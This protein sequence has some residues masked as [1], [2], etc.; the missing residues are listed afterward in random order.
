MMRGTQRIALAGK[1]TKGPASR[2]TTGWYVGMRGHT[3]GAAQLERCTHSQVNCRSY[4]RLAACALP[5]LALVGCSNSAAK[6]PSTSFAA[7]EPAS[8]PASNETALAAVVPKSPVGGGTFK[9]GKPYRIKGRWYRP[10][11]QPSYDKVG[12]AS[13]YGAAFHGKRTANGEIYNMHALTAAHPTLPIP[14]L[15]HVTNLENGRSLVVRVNDRGPYAHDRII[16]LSKKSAH[17]LGFTTKGTA[18]VRVKY[19]RRAPLSG[20]DTFERAHLTKQSWYAQRYAATFAKPSLAVGPRIAGPKRSQ[21]SR[22][23]TPGRTRTERYFVRAGTFRDHANA[24]RLSQ[25]LGSLGPVRVERVLRGSV[26]LYQV[27][28]GPYSGSDSAQRALTN[29]KLAGANDALIVAQ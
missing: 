25:S 4:V 17:H 16:D 12:V 13:W 10:R 21:S 23:K 19:L 18:K 22:T 15:V 7:A 27:H 11:H 3:P 29:V 28:V 6:A 8:P 9:V 1:T 2:L 24:K 14:S 20:D 5:L 26:P